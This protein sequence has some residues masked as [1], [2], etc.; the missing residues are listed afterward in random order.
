VEEVHDPPSVIPKATIAALGSATVLY[1]VVA[2]TA[3]GVLGSGGVAGA[4]SPLQAAMAVVGSGVG[5]AV[6]AAGALLTTFNEGLSDLLGVSRVAFAMAREGDLPRGLAVAGPERNPWRSVLVVGTV[7][8]LVAGFAPFGTAVAIS[9]FGTLL[10]YS[11]TNLSALRLAPD[12]R[13]YHSAVAA[14]GLVG[15]LVLAF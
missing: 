11:V 3:L 8:V 7:A 2:G 5:V 13:M 10:Y 9:S 1:L 14:A 4:A 15:C 6:V 12:K